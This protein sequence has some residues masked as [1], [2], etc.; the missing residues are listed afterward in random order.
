MDEI[1]TVSEV[2]DFLKV[3]R[4]TVWRWCKHGNLPAFKIGRSWRIHRSVVE[5]I[6]SQLPVAE[7]SSNRKLSPE[8]DL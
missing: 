7:H 5:R 6:I 1:L 3:S 2:A 4:T 8:E